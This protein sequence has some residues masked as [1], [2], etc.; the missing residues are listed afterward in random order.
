MNII[1]P[2]IAPHLPFGHDASVSTSPMSIMVFN[3]SQKPS[4][5]KETTFAHVPRFQHSYWG[6]QRGSHLYQP[7]TGPLNY[8]TT[9]QA[10]IDA[11]HPRREIECEPKPNGGISITH[12]VWKTTFPAV[13]PYHRIPSQ[14]P[15]HHPSDDML[16]SVPPFPPIYPLAP[17]NRIQ[18]KNLSLRIPRCATMPS[19]MRVSSTPPL[20]HLPSIDRWLMETLGTPSWTGAYPMDVTSDECFSEIR[21]FLSCPFR[22][23][24]VVGLQGNA[25]QVFVDFLDQVSGNASAPY[26]GD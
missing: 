14:Y 21:A 16:L 10:P 19:E 12:R 11:S 1:N 9:R 2:Q 22:V 3:S 24:A 23:T 13:V 18:G 15:L 17:A 6:P 4:M 20:L 7:S 5:N 26:L 8:P 25:A